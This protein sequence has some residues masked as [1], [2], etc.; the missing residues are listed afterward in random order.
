MTRRTF[1][2][3]SKVF[4]AVFL[5]AAMAAAISASPI[6][7]YKQAVD[8]D[9]DNVAA[10]Y[11]LGLAYY[12]DQQY[13]NAVEQLRAA[14]DNNR[15]DAAAHS[16]IDFQSAQLLGIIYF[17][18]K[19]DT[20][21]AV[22]FFKKAQELKPSDADNLY[23]LGLALKKAGNA[24]EARKYFLKALSSGADNGA[25]INFR[26][27]QICYDKKDYSG[28]LKFFEKVAAEKPGMAEAR[29]YLGDIYD[30]LGNADR[31]VE[32]YQLV[33]KINPDNLHAQYQ[34]GLNYFK[35][36]EY[37]RM[38]AAYK[39]AISIDPK[40]ASAHYN[41]GMAYFYRNMYDEAITELE[42]AI[43]LDPDDAASY[44]LLAQ[45]KT[46]GYE[47]YKSKGA[48]SLTGDDLF[49]AR[50]EFTRALELKPGDAETRKF[51][52]RAD[53]SISKSIPEKLQ[54][55]S[56]NFDMKNY[57]EAYN[58]WDFVLKADPGNGEAKDGMAK[59]DKNLNGLVS[60]RM[61]KAK[62]LENE[63]DLAGA[64]SEYSAIA[65]I[66][67]KSRKKEINDSLNSL[68]SKLTSSVKTAVSE[69]DVFYAKKAF[70]KALN[71]YS[72]ALK[73]DRNN[74][75]ALNGITRVN[76]AMAA[77]E[78]KYM[79]SAKKYSGSN[80]QKSISFYKKV[81]EIDPDN[82][83][84]DKEIVAMTGTQSAAA[85]DARKIKE[86]YYD[87]VDKYVN[88]DVEDAIKIWQ[89]VLAM[90]PNYAEAKKNI[91]RSREKLQAIKNLSR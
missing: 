60:A 52:D 86:L 8:K 32:N 89:K 43:K 50:D 58:D 17:N 33:I 15:Q 90:D 91:A 55:A 11:N 24:D 25:E 82:Q 62:N 35:Q 6:D 84:A 22:D 59:L 53:D 18:F 71:K 85:V 44:A 66:A 34:L 48:A 80:R 65:Q 38:I 5:A 9:A 4:F 69:A 30:K 1:M 26:I 64:I 12:Q 74:A 63:G 54:A 49:A 40:F 13:D 31:A 39:K 45:A 88:G 2:K 42:T 36:K 72:E 70:R 81:L 37:D 78:D 79:A 67:P 77:D 27:G 16:R 23:Y 7:D 20:Q 10:R 21:Q 29:E 28:A 56:K 19:N 3:I 68:M 87:G 75:R 61:V 57:G 73:Y 76:A 14:L 83:E 41:L 46:T 47:Y 51:L